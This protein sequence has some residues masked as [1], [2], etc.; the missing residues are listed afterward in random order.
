MS[1]SVFKERE[2]ADGQTR[3]ELVVP[4]LTLEEAHRLSKSLRLELDEHAVVRDEESPDSGPVDVTSN[5][6]ES[7]DA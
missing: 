3:V 4:H 1:Y 6:R 2:G 5:E 7:E